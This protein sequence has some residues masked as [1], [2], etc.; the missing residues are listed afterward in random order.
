M[1]RKWLLCAVLSLL[2]VCLLAMSAMAEEPA[3]GVAYQTAETGVVVEAQEQNGAQYLFLPASA[4]Y[5]AL[6]LRIPSGAVLTGSKPGKS[7][8]ADGSP[9]DLTKLFGVMEA[10]KTYPL[11]VRHEG[12]EQV[13]NLMKSAN[14]ASL[15]ITLDKPI[16]EINASADKSVKGKG[17]LTMVEQDGS[18]LSA[19]LKQLKGRGNSSWLADSDKKPYN[20]KL[21]KKQELIGGAGAAKDW[22]L[23]ANNN[24]D[25]TGL[26][27]MLAYGIYEDIGGSSALA[28]RNV[29]LYINGEY[30]GTYFLT[31]K[32]EIGSERVDIRESEYAV[33]DEERVVRV[34]TAGGVNNEP[35]G[36]NEIPSG[37]ANV[38]TITMGN[39][40]GDPALA[41]GI[42]A[43][44][45][46]ADSRL[47]PGGAGGYLL[48]VDFRFHAE[49]SW[50]VTRRGVAVVVKEPEFATRAQVQ[51]IAA[52]VQGFEDALFSDSGYNAQG[53]HYSEYVEL[54][55]LAKKYLVDCVSAQ[56]D[57]AASSAY[58]YMD[59]DESGALSGTM[60][61][62]PAWD[63]DLSY[64][65]A[66]GLFYER[67][68]SN[69]ERL[70]NAQ[71]AVQLLTKGDFLS[72]LREESEALRPI[73]EALIAG[74]LQDYINEVAASQAMSD[75]CWGT[76]FAAGAADCK[77]AFAARYTRWYG[78]VWS[79][80][81]VC[82]VTVTEE[83]GTLH[84]NVSGEADSV[85]WYRVDPE[86][87]YA[88]LLQED[89]A[90]T[91][92]TP[93]RAGM[94]LAAASGGNVGWQ[95]AVN[96]H[97]EWYI[98]EDGTTSLVAQSEITLY[99]N[100]VT[101]AEQPYTDIAGNWAEKSIN[102]LTERGWMMGV[103]TDRFAP[104]SKTTRGEVMM[105]L[106]LVSG[107]KLTESPLKEGMAW[108]VERGISN[109]SDP[110]KSISR[111][112]LAAMLYRYAGEP[113]VEGN[114]D[115]FTDG[116]SVSSYARQAV[117]WAVQNGIMSGYGDDTLRPFG[118]ATRAHVAVMV[119]RLCENVK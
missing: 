92:Y 12:A 23:L 52:H 89:A 102:Y 58:Y 9:M 72:C 119:Q 19:E 76:D 35:Y 109:G 114:L 41:A 59:V 104:G 25:R 113:E 48:E 71:W 29:D 68:G 66:K 46:A 31:E 7:L 40:S 105:T 53:K 10:G 73:W 99:S 97:P 43:Y 32:V 38:S 115:E 44:Q 82:G 96:M 117:I 88:L 74:G 98:L 33:E 2:A 5:D 42:Q 37:S 22:C 28:T 86:N 20:I 51:Q 95:S 77:A 55:S 57:M 111:Q 107:E 4:K 13:V 75:V 8:T 63:Y 81:R 56:A 60:C 1:K 84:A 93:L 36:W 118:T 47:E 94:Y 16:S 11:T 101:L 103:S 116:E 30:R 78:E 17:K 65:T 64:Y 112:Q 100:P 3:L 6:T 67:I 49:A 91:T 24:F 69:L 110:E 18:A 90:G 39:S 61:A 26:C 50:F 106:A 87:D 85:H 21:E 108:A 70:K 54:E 34:V 27:N 15:H 83:N 62:G 80:E 14:I 45:Y 79:A